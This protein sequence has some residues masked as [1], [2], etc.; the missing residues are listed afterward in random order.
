MSFI[1]SFLLACYDLEV[2]GWGSKGEVGEGS[3][4]QEEKA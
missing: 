2:T 1:L 4:R 3:F